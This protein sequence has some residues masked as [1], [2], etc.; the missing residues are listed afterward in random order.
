MAAPT[1]KYNLFLRDAETQIA[2]IRS[3]LTSQ[4]FTPLTLTD[5]IAAVAVLKETASKVEVDSFSLVIGRLEKV[6][7]RYTSAQTLPNQ[8]ALEMAVLAVDWLSQLIILYREVLPEPQSLLTELLYS[9]DLMERSLGAAELTESAV[10]DRVDMFSEDPSFAVI[11]HAATSLHD[12]FAGDPGFG[13]EFDLLQR[14][15]S[16]VVETSTIAAD[17]FSEDP[18]VG[19]KDDNYL[20]HTSE[21]RMEQSVYDFF[22]EDPPLSDEP[23]RQ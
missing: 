12:P 16:F 4:I 6:L 2:K 22:A 3:S 13:L 7:L 5:A 20:D 17:P 18:V 23:D 21:P 8:V 15:I 10:L 1:S 11:A 14:T 9:F 19:T